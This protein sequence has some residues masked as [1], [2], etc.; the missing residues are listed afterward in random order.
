MFN[1]IIKA[2]FGIVYNKAD[3]L[4]LIPSW[5]KLAIITKQISGC[6]TSENVL[7]GTASITVCSS[8]DIMSDQVS[9]LVKQNRH[10]VGCSSLLNVI[11]LVKKI[12]L[13]EHNV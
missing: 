12:L 2:S 1:R 4:S 5:K 8:N 6:L 11:N 10:M 3:L 9:I 7:S 13:F